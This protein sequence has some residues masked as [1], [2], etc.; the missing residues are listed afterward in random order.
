MFSPQTGVDWGYKQDKSYVFDG[1]FDQN[2]ATADVYQQALEPAIRNILNG[3]NSTILAYGM[4][5]AG[6][7]FTMFGDIYNSLGG[8]KVHPGIVS[9]IVKDL[10][11]AFERE[12]DNG[13][14]FSI[15]LSYLE[16]YNEHARDL[17]IPSTEDLMIVED[18]LRG[19]VIPNISELL[20]KSHDEILKL[21]LQGNA[22][23]IMASTHANQFSSRSHAII[24]LSIEKRSKAKNTIDSCLQ[25]KL[26]LVDLAGSERAAASDNRGLRHR[27]GANI[28]R[29][30]LALGNCI[31][32][33]SD[34]NKKGAFVPYRDS[35]LTRLLK[36][37]L[38][39]NTRTVML[40]CV[41]PAYTAYEETVNTLNYA[42]RAR[43]IKKKI[44][45]NVK[46]VDLHVSQYKEVIESLRLEVER[47]KVKLAE[48]ASKIAY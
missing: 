22:R 5:G 38:G 40:A 42:S 19:T 37:S 2:S 29:S 17:L 10:F 13:Y 46:E 4:T 33:L 45:K 8:L 16:I 15:K 31:N 11:S 36:D 3:Y 48:S 9:L 47:L 7:T 14:D 6:K 43:N 44:T 25:S 23:R 35:K 34:S 20:I 28:N 12:S 1:I 26:C 32:I 18:P 30:L 21:I 39:G 24:Q 27:E 41:S